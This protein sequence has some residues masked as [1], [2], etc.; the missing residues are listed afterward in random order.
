LLH[1]GVVNI[2]AEGEAIRRRFPRIVMNLIMAFIF[3][4]MS[5]FIP[6]TVRSIIIPGINTDASLLIW[7]LTTVVMAI[8]LIRALS[9]ALVLGDVVTDILVRR[10]GIKEERSP[11]RA[12]REF[13]YIIIIVL[14]VTAVSP[15]LAAIK[16][17]GFY[18]TTAATYIGL[19]FVII[20]IYDIGRILYKIIEQKAELLADRLAQMTEKNKNGD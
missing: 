6:P 1:H 15:I 4:I 2:K 10:L 18:L 17:V 8:F 11:K 19:A 14:I 5:V 3:W 9:D 7:I 13:I 20:L 12:A 16:D